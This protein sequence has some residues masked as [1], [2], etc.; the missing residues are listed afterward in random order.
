MAKIGL[1]DPYYAVVTIGE[2][3]SSPGTETE[4]IG[5]AKRLAKAVQLQANVNAPTVKLYADDGVAESVAEF[6]EGTGTITVDELEDDAAADLYSATALSTSNDIVNKATDVCAYVRLGFVI[7]RIKNGTESYRGIVLARAQF[8]I[9]SDTWDTK[10]ENITLGTSQLP[11]SFYRDIKGVWR[12]MSEWKTS[13]S[14]ANTWMK[15]QL[16]QADLSTNASQ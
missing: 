4:S 8:N 16:V 12:K 7:R 9:P 14:T 15:A 10:G 3:S 1:R 5:T 13:Y 11:F 2:D 6:I